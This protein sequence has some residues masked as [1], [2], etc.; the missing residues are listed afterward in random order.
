[1]L[2]PA[3]LDAYLARIGFEGSR[4]PSHATLA[5]IQHRHVC[6]IPF[7]NLDIQLGRGI[8]IDLPSI[9]QKLVHNQR[10]GYCFEQNALLRAVLVTLGYQ[11]TPLLARVRWLVPPE[12]E[13][14]LTHMVLV[15]EIDGERWLVDGGFGSG[16]LTA[17]LRIDLTAPQP[18]PHD[19]RRVVRR[20]ELYVQQT[21]LTGDWSD[22][23]LFT[24]QPALNIDYEVA[25]WYT[26][27]APQSRFM[28]NLVAARADEGRKYTILNREFTTRWNDGRVEKHEISSGDELLEVL[29]SHL[30]LRFPAGT[31]FPRW[32]EMPPT[33]VK[34]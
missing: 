23:Y 9:V 34:A 16:S 29:A 24:L 15:V 31:R 12:Q 20:G 27:T 11:V 3:D 7:E 5:Q 13:T 10:G 8:R 6:S 17:P 30:N 2:T 18:T 22:L 21:T 33:L 19:P 25:N 4:D 26:S 1:M 14:A 28:L 32:E